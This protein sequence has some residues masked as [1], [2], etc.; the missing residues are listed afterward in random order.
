MARSS[1]SAGPANGLAVRHG[2]QSQSIV[3]ANLPPAVEEVRATLAEHLT[4]AQPPDALLIEQLARLLVRIRLVDA[5]YDKLG[6]SMVD[7]QGRPRRSWQMYLSLIRE[8]RAMA[9][10]LGIGPAARAALVGDLAGAQRDKA[11]TE[12]QAE[13]AARYGPKA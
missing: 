11:A 9:A 1:T 3:T 6:G 13:L 2:A 7:S 4:Y 12:A 5:Y 8:F 10:A